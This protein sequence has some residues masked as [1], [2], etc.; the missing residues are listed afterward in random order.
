MLMSGEFNRLSSWMLESEL[1]S[2]QA[3]K[4]NR[5]REFVVLAFQIPPL[6]AFSF[7][8]LHQYR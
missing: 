3:H 1:A 5:G 6:G 2:S 8:F 4:K 7:V